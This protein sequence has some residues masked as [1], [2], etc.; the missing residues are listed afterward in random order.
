EAENEALR[1]EFLERTKDSIET[2]MHQI[3]WDLFFLQRVQLDQH[4]DEETLEQ[5]RQK[6]EQFYGGQLGFQYARQ[7]I[8]ALQSLGHD[9]LALEVAEKQLNSLRG[10]GS[11]EEDLFR[12]LIGHIAGAS[13]SV[14]ADNLR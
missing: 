6:T 14:G 9:A 8:L 4:I 7:Y 11:R 13:S 10:T 12:L 3:L 2:P 1:E 5:L